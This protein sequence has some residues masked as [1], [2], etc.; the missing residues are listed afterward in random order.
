[1]GVLLSV[2]WDFF[3]PV[4]SSEE[5]KEFLYD[6]GHNEDNKKIDGTLWTIRAATFIRNGKELPGTSG[7]ET[8]F[9]GRFRIGSK[10]KLFLADSHASIVS[11]YI[12]RHYFNSVISFDAHHDAS[13]ER[14]INNLKFT[15][16]DWVH[17][18]LQRK[19]KVKVVYPQWKKDHAFEEEPEAPLELERVVDDGDPLPYNISSI[20]ICRSGTW[21]P[22][23]LDNQFNKL[24]SGCPVGKRI[25]VGSLEKRTFSLAEAAKFSNLEAKLLEEKP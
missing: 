15:C 13:Y 2:D 9:W 7:K 20:F 18:F 8:S 19:I 22:S 21:V 6:W 1:M 11:D 25:L 14:P 16:E 10:A 4:P 5:D 17:Y 24:I 23:W 12:T 3:F